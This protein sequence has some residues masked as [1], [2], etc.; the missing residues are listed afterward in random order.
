MTNQILAYTNQ[1]QLDTSRAA[2]IAEIV[3]AVKFPAWVVRMQVRDMARSGLLIVYRDN[4]AISAA[5]LA[6]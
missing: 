5:G 2:T 4:V 1:H 3:A 6:L